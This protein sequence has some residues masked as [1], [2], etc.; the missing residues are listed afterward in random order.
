MRTLITGS[1]ILSVIAAG[2][3]APTG[4]LA[5]PRPS[6]AENTERAAM[7]DV[8]HCTRNL[9]TISIVDGDDAYG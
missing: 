2:L 7:N 4:L 5:A 1:A 3:A 6:G 8:P 9:G